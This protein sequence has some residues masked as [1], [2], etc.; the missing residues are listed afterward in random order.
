MEII[1][2]NE[3]TDKLYLISN[4]GRRAFWAALF[5]KDIRNENKVKAGSRKNMEGYL[6]I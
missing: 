1:V 5:L 4:A 6:V 3:W 2:A